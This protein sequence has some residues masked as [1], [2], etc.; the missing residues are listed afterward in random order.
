MSM[1]LEIDKEIIY[2]CGARVATEQQHKQHLKR[3][4]RSEYEFS[5]SSLYTRMDC[6]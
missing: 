2:C 1:N 4:Y 6:I 5:N 3:I